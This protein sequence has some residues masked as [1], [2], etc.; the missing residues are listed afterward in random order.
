M[1]VMHMQLWS[2]MHYVKNWLHA[3]R[4]VLEQDVVTQ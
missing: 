4:S 3:K 2:P 1:G